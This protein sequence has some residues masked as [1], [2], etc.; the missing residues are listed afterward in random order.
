MSFGQPLQ[1]NN[2]CRLLVRL[3]A[4]ATMILTKLNCTPSL[5]HLSPSDKLLFARFGFGPRQT[6]PFGCVH[7]A[8]EHYAQLQPEAVAVEHL[9]ETITYAELDRK[10]NRLAHCL[11]TAGVTSGSRVCLLVQ[12]SIA[13]VVGIVAVLKAGAAYVP[14]DGGIVTQSTLEFVLQDSEAVLVLCLKEYQ[15]RV[16]EGKLSVCLEEM[17]ELTEDVAKPEDRSSPDDG[18]YVIYTSGRL[19]FYKSD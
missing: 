12:R 16:P 2:C 8:F 9:G 5:D 4:L 13:M 18:V 3:L 15:N 7:H 14:L 10:A 17:M 1:Q 6:S 11:R 19:Y